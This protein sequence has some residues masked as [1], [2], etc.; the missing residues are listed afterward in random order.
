[1]PTFADRGCA[2]SAQ[3]IP[4]AVNIGF[5]D[6]SRYFSIQAAPQ[7]SSR[8]WVD[9]VPEPL[10]L[11]FTFI[12]WLF[13]A[14]NSAVTVELGRLVDV[15]FQCQGVNNRG[16]EQCMSEEWLIHKILV[17]LYLIIYIYYCTLRSTQ[18]ITE[19]ARSKAWTIFARL[20]NGIVGSNPTRG[21][22]FCVGLFRV[23]VVLQRA[24]PR[25]WSPTN[26]VYRLRNW[27]T[28]KVQRAVG[29]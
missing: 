19:T 29:P 22:D 11:I 7:L 8:G 13:T 1:V 4:T 20:N 24:E 27:K 16:T 25:S 3:Q 18:P 28:A 14:V 5:L 26:Y 9:P 23:C 10:L 21:M 6:R 2:W 12:L 17:T 15:I